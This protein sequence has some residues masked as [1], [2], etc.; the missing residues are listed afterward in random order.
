MR[1]SAS[2]FSLFAFSLLLSSTITMAENRGKS[3]SSSSTTA[4]STDVYIVYTGK[5]DEGVDPE[6]HHLG[7]LSSVIGSKEAAKEAL[8][9]IY[10]NAATGF[11]AK[12]TPEQAS[13]LSKQPGVLQVVPSGTL[14][15]HSGAGKMNMRNY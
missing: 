10:K 14:Q 2:L 11:S 7:T 3:S 6:S 13:E 8:I 1:N 4:P 15:L 5:P 9:Y 12:L